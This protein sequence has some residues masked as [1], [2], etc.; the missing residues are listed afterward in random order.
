MS[1]KK[2]NTTKIS[3]QMP[4]I[5]LSKKLP[6]GPDVVVELKPLFKFNHSALDF[7]KM[8]GDSSTVRRGR[9]G[10]QGPGWLGA[11]NSAGQG[12]GPL[13]QLLEQ[14]CLLV[15]EVRT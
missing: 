5:D 4:A 15:A 3:V 6:A 14:Q 10:S 1:T 7:H 12:G 2:V 13:H 11:A 8:A 9:A